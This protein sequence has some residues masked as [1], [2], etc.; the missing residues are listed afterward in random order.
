VPT[1]GSARA[2]AYVAIASIQRNL[3]QGALEAEQLHE[4]ALHTLSKPTVTPV[5]EAPGGSGGLEKVLRAQASLV[6]AL[7]YREDGRSRRLRCSQARC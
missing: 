6:V 4:N 2:Y 1:W 5:W 3:A 7:L